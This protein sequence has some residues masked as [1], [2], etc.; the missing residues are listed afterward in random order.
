MFRLVNHNA[1]IEHPGYFAEPGR[2]RL[3]IKWGHYPEV[4]GK[5]D[6]ATLTEIIVLGPEGQTT[7]VVGIDKDSSSK[8]AIFLE[9]NACS[10]GLYTVLL[11]YNRG[12]YTITSTGSWIY[13]E[14]DRV[15]ALGYEVKDTYRIE[16]SAKTLVPVGIRDNINVKPLGVGL[17]ITP[18]INR[19]PEPG[20]EIKLNVTLDS[21]PVPN[22]ELIIYSS[23]GKETT[24]TDNNG[25]AT[26]RLRRGI[27]V[28][29]CSTTINKK[30]SKFKRRI[31]TSLTLCVR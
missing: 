18:L 2:A 15:K 31:T 29:V 27:N 12:I 25:V 19:M 20:E 17:E 11:R 13:A 7:A 22:V 5:I 4:D 9:F 23:E 3:Y 26:V 28:I 1:W 16:G 14:P 8:G 21:L 6:P 24:R 30:E 10:I